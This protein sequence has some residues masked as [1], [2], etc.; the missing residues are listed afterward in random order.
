MKI[1]PSNIQSPKQAKAFTEAKYIIERVDQVV[2]AVDK[3]DQSESDFNKSDGS[4][5]VDKVVI[6]ESDGWN[7]R[8]W[9]DG[10]ELTREGDNLTF[11]GNAELSGSWMFLPMGLDTAV[12]K[13]D[14]PTRTTYKLKF[15]GDVSG[16]NTQ[17]VEVDKTT[18]EWNLK[19]RW[20]GFIPA[21][22]DA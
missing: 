1:N 3:F 2:A 7:P 12:S 17:I 9:T 18:G 15:E 14:S 22:F 4:V 10:A 11:K 16:P 20:M 13:S 6:A 19:K 8:R 21:S 5:L